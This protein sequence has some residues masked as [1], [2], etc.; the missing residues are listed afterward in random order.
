MNG[1]AVFWGLDWRICGACFSDLQNIVSSLDTRLAEAP[2]WPCVSFCPTESLPTTSTLRLLFNPAW[3]SP[4]YN[5][6]LLQQQ[7]LPPLLHT[8]IILGQPTPS[9][10]RLPLQQPPP[11]PLRMS[12]IRTRPRQHRQA[13]WLQQGTGT[14]FSS[15]SPP[16][17]PQEL[18]LLLPPS[19]SISLSSC[20]QIACSKSM[21]TSLKEGSSGSH[22]PHMKMAKLGGGRGGPQGSERCSSLSGFYLAVPLLKSL[23]KI[24]K[25]VKWGITVYFIQVRSVLSVLNI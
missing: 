4:T 9:T 12:S 6:R 2:L 3:W 11:P 19:A 15:R 25:N 5:L 7:L 8:S 14:L 18:R 24:T 13:T 21:K 17:P 23:K 1:F 16:L 22:P 20:R 10:L